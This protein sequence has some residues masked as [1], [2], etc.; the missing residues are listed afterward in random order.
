MNERQTAL[1]EY[2][3]DFN[4]VSWAD[5]LVAG[6]CQ[7]DECAAFIDALF[8]GFDRAENPN[9]DIQH[10]ILDQATGFGFTGAE[11]VALR[12][13]NTA[14]DEIVDLFAWIFH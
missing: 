11:K 9:R 2:A 3:V 8:D 4:G 6:D 14:Q 10:Y 13:G 1:Y 12:L 7:P 5:A